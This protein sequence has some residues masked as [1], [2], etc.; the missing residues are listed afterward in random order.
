MLIAEN[1]P[2]K[3]SVDLGRAETEQSF[4]YH[5]RHRLPAFLAEHECHL[6]LSW[7]CKVCSVWEC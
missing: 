1:M 3:E 5:T 2:C 6:K 4:G 7:R